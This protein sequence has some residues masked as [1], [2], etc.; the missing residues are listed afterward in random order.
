MIEEIWEERPES[1][2]IGGVT[3]FMSKSILIID[4]PESC[5]YCDYCHTKDYD[6]MKQTDGE[7]FCG[8]ENMNVDDFFNYENQRKPDWC[9]LKELPDK[10]KSN[11][12]FNEC[13][14]GYVY[15]YGLKGIEKT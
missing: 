13:D 8:I 7:K 9:P 3:N 5:Y 6:Y 15:V 11:G 2:K 12:C 10:E 1:L 14:D 4:T